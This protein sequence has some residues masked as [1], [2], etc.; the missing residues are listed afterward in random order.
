MA[1]YKRTRDLIYFL[2]TAYVIKSRG[3]LRKQDTPSATTTFHI[4]PGP[5]NFRV[6]PSWYLYNFFLH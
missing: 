6:M 2:L 4:E 1:F 3:L 5:M